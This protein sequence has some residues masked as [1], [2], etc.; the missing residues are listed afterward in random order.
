MRRL[1]AA[2]VGAM[3][4]VLV[5]VGTV[6]NAAA[7]SENAQF[8]QCIAV[9]AQTGPNEHAEMMGLDNFGEVVQ[10][11]QAMHDPPAAP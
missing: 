6:A 2:L 3:I 9:M 1:L 10:H 4:V 5:S 8:G 7:Q 11:C